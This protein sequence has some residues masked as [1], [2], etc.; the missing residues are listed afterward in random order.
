MENEGAYRAVLYTCV[1]AHWITLLTA[2]AVVG[3]IP[4]SPLPLIGAAW[5][6]AGSIPPCTCLTITLSCKISNSPLHICRAVVHVNE[7]DMVDFGECA[8]VSRNLQ[9]AH[10]TSRASN[11]AHFLTSDV[12]FSIMI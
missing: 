2:V 5:P 7:R 3:S 12:S 1:A 9:G 8:P 6:R 10:Q 11:R 4:I